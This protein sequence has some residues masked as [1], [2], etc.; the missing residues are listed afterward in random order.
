VPAEGRE[1]EPAGTR[2]GFR[3]GGRAVGGWGDR[4]GTGAGSI[5]RRGIREVRPSA[6]GALAPS[7]LRG[8]R[9]F[10][11]QGAEPLGPSLRLNVRECGAPGAVTAG[12]GWCPG[13]G[14]AGRRRGTAGGWRRPSSEGPVPL[15]SGPPRPG[16]EVLGSRC[17][18][19]ALNDRLILLF[20]RRKY[21]AGNIQNVEFVMDEFSICCNV[22]SIFQGRGLAFVVRVQ[23][24]MI[25]NLV[26]NV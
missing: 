23:V 9:G 18:R 22:L 16:E 21:S 13:C 6:A 5:S 24:L 4:D 7:V 2:E 20:P 25:L 15:S 17:G 8:A 10:A 26:I 11:L 12:R 19:D 1:V 3:R 14:G